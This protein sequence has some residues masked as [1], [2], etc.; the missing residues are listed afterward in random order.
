MTF[1][2]ILSDLGSGSMTP[3]QAY[4]EVNTKDK[5]KKIN[6]YAHWGNIKTTPLNDVQLQEL[7]SIVDILQ[8]LYTS[9]VDSPV[10]D[11]TYDALQETLIDMGIPRLTGSV[12]I[13]DDTKVHHK[14]TNLR[15][16]LDKVYYLSLDEPRTN[17]SRK[18]LDEW[19][20]RMETRYKQKTD[21]TINLNE[22][23]VMLQP[24]FDG[25]SCVLEGEEKPLWITRGDTRNNLASDVSHIMHIFNDVYA[26]PNVGVK[27]EVMMTEDNKNLINEIYRDHP[28]H[29]S[30]QI[31]T[32]I[33]NSN[34]IDFKAEYLYP[35]P[36][37]ITHPGDKTEQIHPMLIEK[38]PTK[39]ITLGDRDAIREFANANRYVFVDG[40]KFR[41]D[42]AV[43]TIL[44]EH[45]KEVLG[46]END[47]NNFEIAYKFTEETAIT[48]VKNIEFYTSAFGIITPVL[49]VN[50]VLMKGN[51]INHISLSN[52]DRFDELDLHYG[53][54][55]KIHYDIIPYATVDASCNRAPNG[56]RIEFVKECPRC[57]EDLDLTT[58]VVQCKNP[59]C[60]SIL[61]GRVMNYCQVLRIQNIGEQTLNVL[62]EIGLLK[63][64]IR[65]LYKLK[66]KT[67][68]IEDLD[69]FGK[70]KTKKIISEIEAKRKLKDYEFFGAIGIIGLSVKTFQVIF[71]HVKLTEIMDMTR[72][73]NFDLMMSKLVGING[74]GEKKAELLVSYLKDADNRTEL[75][76]LMDELTLVSTFGDGNISKGTVVFTGCRPDVR[77]EE[78]IKLKGYEPSTS[79]SKKAKYLVIPN[80]PSF[81]S[82][83]L[84]N[85]TNA[86]V[87]IVTISEIYDVL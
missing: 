20:K 9:D 62:Y 60:P 45:I 36:L 68:V 55:V 66:K 79:W 43:M 33:L 83:K 57:H 25:V 13:N 85:A 15:G 23:K 56:R 87:P 19:I 49:V 1:E 11:S 76:K 28:Y 29:N 24:K 72:L 54:E 61:I 44:D 78:F 48:K 74:I 58:T 86:N 38:F 12:E 65:S 40:M 31:V 14:Y 75:L 71:S 5:L 82:N 18:Y 42:G 63:H 77:L 35:V 30:R 46:R 51:T 39:V 3:Q 53:D 64:G 7:Q 6:F 32:S 4:D 17:K 8:I 41:T 47:I 10:E 27:F 37:R 70:L 50:D 80:N 22:V 34:E 26:E 59:R 69:G 21:E 52:K 16:T 73:K 67:S 81:H 84:D 2:K